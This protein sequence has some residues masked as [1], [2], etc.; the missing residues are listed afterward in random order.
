MEMDEMKYSGILNLLFSKKGH[1]IMP[2]FIFGLLLIILLPLP[3][4][5]LD[6]LITVN[7]SISISV[8]LV[9]MYI[10][11]PIEFSSFPSIMLVITLFRLSLN[12][13]STKL[14]LLQG[15]FG[16]TAAGRVIETFGQHVAGGNFIVGIVIFAVIVVVNFLVVAK[17]AVR[18]SEVTA[19]F[20]LDA[21]PGKQ[22]A[23]DADLN[24]GIISEQDAKERRESIQREADFYGKM[25]GASRFS[26]KDAIAS[27]IITFINII[28]G[29]LIGVLQKD[30]DIGTAAQ[31]YIIL[32]IGDGLV[33]AI[34]SLLISVSAGM[35]A[36]RSA[37]KAD[38]GE[39]ILQQLQADP[40]PI[41]I[42]SGILAAL[43]FTPGMPNAAFLLMSMIFGALGFVAIKEKKKEFDKEKREKISKPDK[44]VK[45]TRESLH[46]LLKVDPLNLELGYRLIQLVDANI[47]GNLLDRIKSIRRQIALD[48]GIIVPPIRIRD[49]LQLENQSYSILLKGSIIAQGSVMTGKLLAMNPGY[50]KEE[51]AGTKT[52]EPA[53]GLPAIWI[54]ENLKDKAQFSGYTVVD[55]ITVIATHLTEIVRKHASDLLGRQELSQMIDTLSETHSKLVDE[56]VPNILDLGT[57][58]KVLKNLLSEGVSVRDLVTI[59]ET[60]ADFGKFIKDSD[61]LTEYVRQAL[62]RTIVQPLINEKQELVVFTL[63]P[64]I[65]NKIAQSVQ[66][67]DMGSFLNMEPDAARDILIKAQRIIE[68]TPLNT[69]PIIIVNPNIRRFVKLLFSKYIENI[70]ILSHNEIPQK[71]RVISIGVIE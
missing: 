53:F 2:A 70:I 27:I 18:I 5:M 54:D 10:L 58:L 36:T 50:V 28:G 40:R 47:K 48:M 19:R 57:V 38:L 7:L 30:M 21:L 62:S 25:D 23:I 59:F 31:V 56:L 4:F 45:E 35:I 17:G 65:E 66:T 16:S 63:S 9:S 60:L 37:S 26:E 3:T 13:A 22:M 41:L 51:I 39:D 44:P 67:T 42:I 24:A 69:Q 29:L 61:L 20:T 1:F 34:P 15:E 43:G 68:K 12:V 33:S 46:S 64:K 52:V 11:N 32:T 49:N 71:I 8:L 55:P 6:I 14:I